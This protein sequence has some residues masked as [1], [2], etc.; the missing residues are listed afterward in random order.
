[1]EVFFISLV[2]DACRAARS[3]GSGGPRR[4]A[5]PDRNEI[6]IAAMGATTWTGQRI[7]DA[8]LAGALARSMALVKEPELH[9]RPAANA[10]YDVVHR[11]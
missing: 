1:L 9:I 2:G 4:A 6:V 7:D 10:R 3:P 11:S 5:K 8:A